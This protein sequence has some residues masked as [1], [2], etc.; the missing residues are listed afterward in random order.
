[1]PGTVIN[2]PILL[3]EAAHLVLEITADADQAGSRHEQRTDDLALRALH[4]YFPIPAHAHQLGQT[5]CIVGIALVDADRQCRM[6]VPRV[7]A[8]LLQGGQSL[9]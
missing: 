9:N 6:G 5:A 3:H 4:A 8:S 2:R 1:M 7:D